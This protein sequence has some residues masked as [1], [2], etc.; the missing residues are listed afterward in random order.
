MWRICWPWHTWLDV[1][2]VLRESAVA[3]QR[4]HADLI[5]ARLDETPA[6]VAEPS[7]SLSDDVVLRSV[8]Y[9]AVR[10]GLHLPDRGG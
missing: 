7:L 1:I 4:E 9:A 8:N 3:H 5:Q 6:D 10:L 2:A